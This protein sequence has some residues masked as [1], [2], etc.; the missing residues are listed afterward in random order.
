MGMTQ[1]QLALVR[2]VAENNMQRAK[3]CAIAC[4]AEDTT[5]KNSMQ[6]AR[7][8]KLLQSGGMNLFEL[9]PN[10]KSIATMEDVTTSFNE[11]RYFLSEQEKIVFQTISNMRDASMQLMEKQVP[12]LNATLL[13]GE[14]G[15]GKTM[16]AKYVAYKLGLP[17]LYINLSML[18]DSHLGGTAKNM[19]NLFNFINQQ[20]CVLMIDEIDFISSNRSGN[21]GSSAAKEV[22]RTTTCLIQLLDTVTNDHVIMAATNI[23]DEVD[24]AIRRRFTLEH[25]MERLKKDECIKLIKMYLDDTGFV[26][27]ESNIAEFAEKDLSQAKIIAHLARCMADAIIQKSSKVIL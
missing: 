7:W 10:V 13:Y 26:Y 4:C 12:Y 27:N 22:A 1:N 6:V 17:Y 8:K 24:P 2:A 14:S 15:I 5:Q 11:K 20:Q 25:K 23:P 18:M 21:D 19:F 16:F 3:Q 9:P